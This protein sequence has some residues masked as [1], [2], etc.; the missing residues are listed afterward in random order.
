M[1][2]STLYGFGR[3]LVGFPIEHP[4]EAIKT[5]WQA[6]PAFRNEFHIVHEVYT[7]KGLY[8]GFYA[9]S[10]PNLGRILIKNSY[11]FPLI[12]GIPVFL[13]SNVPE[14]YSKNKSMLKLMSGSGISVFESL[15]LC[16]FERMR[17][18]FMTVEKTNKKA[19]FIGYFRSGGSPVRDLFRGLGSLWLRQWVSWNYFLQIDLFL[20]TKIRKKYNIAE[21][22]KLP[23]KYIAPISLLISA[24]QTM[25]IMPF[26]SLKTNQQLFSRKGQDKVISYRETCELIMKEAGVRGFFVGWRLR[27]AMYMI[28]SVFAV[29]IIENM[30]HK[31]KKE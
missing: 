18:Y 13:E 17:T 2:L 16:P 3:G 10:T 23:N 4:L 28:N 22:E 25:L 11:R 5:Q 26:D 20:K 1:G 15:I 9:G 6:K 19:T 30:E 31:L 8:R 27:F 29:F 7:T 21:N 12:V 24:T 14:K